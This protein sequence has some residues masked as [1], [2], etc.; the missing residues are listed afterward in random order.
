VQHAASDTKASG[1][2]TRRFEL[3]DPSAQI[4]SDEFRFVEAFLR[5]TGRTQ[6]GWHYITDLTWIYRRVRG[7]PRGLR[8]LDAGGGSNGPLQY[9]L[10]ELGFDVVNVDLF[11]SEV[12]LACRRRYRTRVRRLASYVPTD[13]LSL[14]APRGAVS[15]A[16]QLMKRTPLYWLLR[17][18]EQVRT[19]D[20]RHD[21]F[22]RR[23]G[24][25]MQ[26]VGTLDWVQGNLCAMPEFAPGSFGAVVSLS[27][28]EHVPRDQLGAAL[29]EIERVLAPGARWA[30]TTSATEAAQTWFH[31]PSRGHCFSAH[32]LRGTF[33]AEPAA[34]QEPEAVLQAY[35]DCAYLREHLADFY[36]RSG[37]LGM[38]WGKWD[39]KYIPVGIESGRAGVSA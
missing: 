18:R 37:D 22:R 34:A 7:W 19:Y 15:A 16:K 9:L 8:I 6:I 27:A 35:R 17:G 28:L 11:F 33:G 23:H 31:E 24:L 25:A 26:P 36:R 20:A 13:Y 32:D 10:A 1:S 38:P 21:E 3:I 12:P 5:A 2:A 30:V 14:L 39:P 29:R 4:E